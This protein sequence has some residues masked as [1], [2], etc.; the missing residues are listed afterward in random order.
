MKTILKIAWRNVWRNKLRSTIVITSIV[1]GIWAALFMM[2]M[3]LGLNEQRLNGAINTYLSH[4]Q[5]HHPKFGEDQNSKYFIENKEKIITA[6][7]TNKDINAYSERMVIGAMAA[8]SSGSYG[9]QILG[10][11]PEKEKKITAI[12]EMLTEGTYFTKFKKRPVIIGKKLA[13]K[14]NLKIKSK[15]VITL[16]DIDGNIVA[17]SYR[18]EGI[19]K[20]S[21]SRLDGTTLFVRKADLETTIGLK[22]EIHEIAI[23]TK[24]LDITSDIKISLSKQAGNNKVETWADVAPELGYAQEMM[25]SFIYIFMGIVLIALA[26]SII[27]TMLMAVLERRRELGMLMSIGMNKTRLAA[28]ITS[29]TVFI[30]MVATPIG[31]LLSYLTISYFEKYG[32][33]LSAVAEGLES[34]GIGSRI[35]TFLPFDLYINITLMT[36][37]V[38]LL[39][40]IFPTKRAL[41]LSPTEAVS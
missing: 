39:S 15:V 11:T 36:L 17:N 21:N 28:M 3:V 1:L 29:E 31:M 24:S 23:V 26:F 30:S 40:S 19:Y 33:D 41:S 9:V 2:A 14:L 20:T 18:V 16:Q 22:G 35:Y 8:N 6:L 4:L 37:I 32:I 38:T 13:D 27:N 12:S 34:L 7:A 25:S 10:I 5:I